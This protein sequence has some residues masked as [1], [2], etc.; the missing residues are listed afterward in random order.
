[1]KWFG[2]C[3]QSSYFERHLFSPIIPIIGKDDFCHDPKIRTP[4]GRLEDVM[5]VLRWVKRILLFL[6]LISSLLLLDYM[7]PNGRLVHVVGTEVKRVNEQVN[8][9]EKTRDV[10]FIA[11]DDVSNG[12]TRVYR[13][14]DAWLYLFKINS[15][16]IQGQAQSLVQ[17]DDKPSAILRYYGYRIQL[18]SMFPNILTLQRAEP[19]AQYTPWLRYIGFGL[20]GFLLLLVVFRFRYF[21]FD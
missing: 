8:G 17:D 9:E 20:Y 13:N 16:D 5:I 10:Y 7:L 6:F 1:M 4:D 18:F 21:V 11:A 14:E 19:E 12:A 15:A 3:S 2:S